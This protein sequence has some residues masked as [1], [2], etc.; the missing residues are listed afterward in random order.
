MLPLL[1]LH[2]HLL[3]NISQQ[4]IFVYFSSPCA[5]LSL[6]RINFGAVCIHLYECVSLCVRHLCP[7]V[8]VR[9]SMLSSI[10]HFFQGGGAVCLPTLNINRSAFYLFA[11]PLWGMLGKYGCKHVFAGV[12]SPVCV[13]VCWCPCHFHTDRE[14]RLR[15]RSEAARPPSRPFLCALCATNCLAFEIPC[16]IVEVFMDWRVSKRG[17]EYGEALQVKRVS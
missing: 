15:P 4:A 2:L 8:C 13:C 3:L 14:C 16:V 10:L 11:S 17:G 9:T 12:S 6:S 5:W 1:L 7:C